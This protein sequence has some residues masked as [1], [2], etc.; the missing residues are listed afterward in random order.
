MARPPPRPAP[1]PPPG[2][3]APPPAAF[4]PP[5]RS[6]RFH[7][8]AGAVTAGASAAAFAL[9]RSTWSAEPARGYTDLGLWLAGAA[10]AL[11]LLVYAYAWRKRAGQ[12][13]LPGRLQTWLRLH[14]WL[15]VAGTWAALLHAGFHVDGGWGTVSL[16]ILAFVMLSG[17]VGWA[18]YVTVPPRV[19]A[20]V[21]NL[22]VAHTERTIAGL[23]RALEAAEAGAS[24]ALSAALSAARRGRG[25]DGPPG[26]GADEARRLEEVR[27]AVARL[28]HERR[29]RQGQLRLQRW[30]RLWLWLHWPVALAL[31][32][33]VGIHAFDALGV[34]REGRPRAPAEHADPFSCRECHPRQVDEWL[35]SMHAMAVSAPTVDLQHRLLVAVERAHVAGGGAPV[36]G[37]LCVRCH[38][39]TGHH[40]GLT[41]RADHEPLLARPT[42]R[43]PASAYGISCVV[44]H[45]ISD[46]RAHAAFE[47]LPREAGVE[48]VDD[49][50]TIAF[51]N[52]DNLLFAPG[53]TQRGAFG[54]PLPVGNA[55]HASERA[56]AFGGDGDGGGQA[57]FCASCHTV[58]VDRPDR[59]LSRGTGEPVKLQ[60]T[61]REW[62]EGGTAEGALS[63]EREGVTC[64]DCHARDLG[65][66]VA[67]VRAF[68]DRGSGGFLPLEQRR[69][70]IVALVRDAARGLLPGDE[71]LAAEPRDGFDLPLPP[72]RRYTH[73][74]TG[75]DHPLDDGTP[76][77]PGT[78]GLSEPARR[79]LNLEL[80][81]RMER[82]I[83]DLLQVAAAVEI[84]RVERGRVRGRLLNLA[85]GHH[86]PAGFAFAREMW[87]EVTRRR[88]A[89]VRVVAGGDGAGG[90]LAAAADLPESERTREGFVNLQAVLWNG[91][92]KPEGEPYHR[93]GETVIQIEVPK[94]LAG[95][96]ARAAGFVDRR[97][98]VLPGHLL[99]FDVAC[100]VEPGD[101][102]TVRLLFRN[103]PPRF[104]TTLAGR[105]RAT[106]GG[107]GGATPEEIARLERL[108]QGLRI[109]EMARD[110]R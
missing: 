18:L 83:E 79:A 33:A 101:E 17:A 36:A 5:R 24:P 66:V 98:P 71:A 58:V 87:L 1:T 30:L 75:V 68:A 57:A 109:R 23:E 69:G 55:A 63:W 93:D 51:R 60:N 89:E 46:V 45:Q 78:L 16:A 39:P 47:R 92:A 84:D 20:S 72:R 64:L 10:S 15:A 74:F 102:V 29:R 99:A 52:I 53:R 49:L 3:P 48:P 90:A 108:V 103:F 88:G 40:P 86:L 82:R 50:S 14:V 105:L 44:C 2:R 35:T 70:R 19:D 4:A 56:P 73:A 67:A 81:A 62:Q 54:E 27:Q 6:A 7:L 77:L 104:L 65:P 43:A 34:G 100:D 107:P 25:G 110:R 31:P 95:P 106:P 41:P 91:T 28:G 11:F 12:E 32:V 61:Y 22:A 26:L 21:G 80:R 8:G 38:A 94:V 97:G 42:E 76:V 96:A 9:A 37:D 59:A 13:L 85:T